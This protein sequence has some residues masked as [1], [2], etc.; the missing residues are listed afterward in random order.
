MIFVTVGT[1]LPFDRLIKRLDKWAEAHPEHEV[2]AQIGEGGFKPKFI[3]FKEK[4]GPIE[5]ARHFDQAELIVAHVG[6]GTIIAGLENSKSMVL[7]PR[8]SGLGEHRS[9][10][11]LDTARKFEHFDLI[12]IVEDINLL[13][14]AIEASLKRDANVFDK[15]PLQASPELIEG[16]RSFV[17]SD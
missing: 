7:V 14:E 15:A 9:D 5:F 17:L 13:D 4:I 11:Q 8:K 16:I 2:F 1:Q 10:H 6:M 3:K 12:S